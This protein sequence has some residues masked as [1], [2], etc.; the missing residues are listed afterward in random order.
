MHESMQEAREGYATI[1]D[2]DA[3]TFARFCEYVYTGD[4]TAAKHAVVRHS[5]VPG[6]DKDIS[7]LVEEESQLQQTSPAGYLEHEST[8][9]G[10]RAIKLANEHEKNTSRWDPFENLQVSSPAHQRVDARQAFLTRA[11]PR[12]PT[13]PSSVCR[14][15]EGP[16]EDYTEVF[17]SHARIYVFADKYDV[18]ALQSLALHSLHK[19][20]AAFTLYPESVADIATLFQYTYQHTA[21]REGRID[22]LRA[23]VLE[24][25]ACNVEKMV[26]N[27]IFEEVLTAESSA[28]S[29]LTKM[30]L[31]R[32]R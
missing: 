28:A 17:L 7:A 12:E 29:D 23:L 16:C 27:E 2:V 25:V 13:A 5:A 31:R 6:K 1:D 22:Q 11:W 26:S 14:P 3:D 18:S 30:L 9:K 20:L 10:K 15:N 19:T 32:L 21:E 4:Y 24:Y 8:K